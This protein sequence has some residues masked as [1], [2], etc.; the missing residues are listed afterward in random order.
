MLGPMRW[1]SATVIAAFVGGALGGGVVRADVDTDRTYRSLAVFA[2]ILGYIETHYVE[3]VPP[4]ALIQGAIRGM[5]TQ[6]D[7]NT[8]Y[9]EAE[10]FAAM[11]TEARGEFGG[12]GV[13]LIKREDRFMVV[14]RYDGSPAEQ[15]G[16]GIGDE[17]AGVDG[18]PVAG[19]SLAELVRRIKGPPDSKVSLTVRR[20]SGKVEALNLSRARIRLTSVDWR[21]LENGLAYVR[22]KT[23]TERTSHDVERALEGLREQRPI[24]G[25]LLDLRDNPGGLLEEAARVADFWLTDGV[26]VT[27]EGRH[28]PVD[29]V[30]AHPHGT[31]PDYPLVVLI[32]GGSA[33]AAEIVAGAL[34]DHQRAVVM[35]N[36]SFGK[37]SVQTVIELE[38]HSALR[39]T[40]ARYYTPQHRSIQGVGITPDV[41]VPS[42]PLVA[43]ASAAAL[44]FPENGPAD[45]QLQAAT[46]L[47]ERWVSGQKRPERGAR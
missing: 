21:S 37:G 23:F 18:A 6:L 15:A 34:Q 16:L 45:P 43:D 2:R 20:Q 7:P 9:L 39:L 32:N 3:Q 22:I 28:R 25:L 29:A 27:T 47:L 1:S 31:E 5:L 8:A 12:V 46:T 33:S 40:I 44:T 36:Q 35:G 13:E 11:K 17:I 30:L 19:W 41:V 38:D 4:S 42:T 14:G 26:I 10:Q 24:K